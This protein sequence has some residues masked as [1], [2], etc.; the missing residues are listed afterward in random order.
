MASSVTLTNTFAAQTGPLQLSTLD[1][2]YSQLATAVNTLSNFANYYVDT[3]SANAIAV[4]TSSPQIFSYVAGVTI[5]VK[6][7]A[8][9]TGATTV[10]VNGTSKNVLSSAGSNLTANQLLANQIYNFTY[11]GTNFYLTGGYQLPVTTNTAGNVTIAAPGS[12]TALTINNANAAA[13]TLTLIQNSGASGST[14]NAQLLLSSGGTAYSVIQ[15]NSGTGT[16]SQILSSGGLSI[17]PNNTTAMIFGTTGTV[18]IQAPSGGNAL[19]LT[20][21]S[22]GYGLVVNTTTTGT[23]AIF[24]SGTAGG[25]VGA[26]FKTNVAAGN[27]SIQFTSASG[28]AGTAVSTGTGSVLC[29]NSTS[30]ANV[31][32]LAVIIDGTTQYIPYWA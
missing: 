10:S 18:T 16:T 30:A 6:V 13:P 11:D 19:T 12:G 17:N 9:N 24:N 1:T 22:T 31:G 3:G 32:W 29:R 23:G 4:T 14:G 25:S 2:N 27:P 21:T 5:T 8:S 15:M 20:S 28:S 7:A 26:V